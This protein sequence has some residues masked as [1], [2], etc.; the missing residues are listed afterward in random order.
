LVESAHEAG[1]PAGVINIVTTQKPGDVSDVW[2]ND[3]RVKKITFTGSTPVGK[4]LMKKAAE[5]VKKVSLELGGLAPFIIAEDAN[6]DEAVNGLI[7]SKFRNAGQTCICANR[8]FV[9][10]TIEQ[11][12]LQAFE[13]A[14]LALKVGNGMEGADLGPLI[15]GAAVKK[16][17]LQ[18]EDAASKGAIIHNTSKVDEK[19]GHFIAPAILSNVTD[20]MLC[21]QE[22]TFG[23]I[24]PV[25]TFKTDQ[26][27]IDRANNTNFGLAA[28]VYTES[29][30]KAVAY[31][32]ALEYGIVGIN[33]SAPSTAQA[34]FGG[35]KESGIG[36][37][38]GHYGMDEYLEVKYI[39]MQLGQ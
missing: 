6:I 14:V 12:F 16:V 1:I 30:N 28:Y 13:E 11:P 22:E 32:D 24:A 33:D 26:E 9:H 2:M 37:E 34:P 39:S 27:A 17:Q 35:M 23:P 29:L 20:D 7:Q 3:S 31:S 38:G 19:Q 18:L 10:E 15:D 21:M 5:T 36:R 4:H 25:S 8:I